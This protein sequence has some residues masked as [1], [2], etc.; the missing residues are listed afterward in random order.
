MIARI[1]I[2]LLLFI[3][4]PDYYLDRRF[5]RKRTRYLWWQ[6]VLWWLP[7]AFMFFY[8]IAL[9]A[10]R[11]FA[12]DNLLLLHI[13]FSLFGI[14]VVPKFLFSLCSFL[15]WAH[16]RY[17][18]THN[19]WGNLVGL[20]L[21]FGAVIAVAYGGTWGFRKV[22][23]RHEEY[24]SADLPKAFDGYRI[25]QFSDAHVGTYGSSYVDMPEKVVNL[26]NK[27]K[28]DMVVFT[29]DLQNMEPKELYPFMPVFE[30][31]KAKDGVFSVLGN[32]DYAEYI[33][34]ES[35]V[36]VANEREL[37]SLERQLGWNLL[38]NEHRVVR[39]GADSIVVAGMENDGDRHFPKRGDIGKT[40]AGVR[41]GAFI[42]ML[43]HDPSSWRRTILPKSAAQLTLSG[44]THVG[45]LKIFGWSPASMN[46]KEWGGMYHEG[47]RAIN[48]SAGMGGF[49]PFRLGASNEIVVI[50]L[51]SEK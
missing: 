20:L 40:L 21:G 35:A 30:R 47:E 10:S 24:R 49:I 34:A 29:G 15:G 9:A 50:T 28:A 4:L 27:Q 11:N 31:I 46:Y 2:Y 18:H 22:E 16:C 23:V 38:L 41:P 14:M 6:R 25:V 5:L 3:T 45:Q 51:K 48:V 42:L 1:F 36:K 7:G 26:I 33:K 12:P 13:Y 39:R 8:T 43:Q 44:H 32:H 19:N 37:V 17:H